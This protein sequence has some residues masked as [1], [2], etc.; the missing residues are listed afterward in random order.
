M[1]RFCNPIQLFANGASCSQVGGMGLTRGAY[2]KP[3]TSVSSRGFCVHCVHAGVRPVASRPRQA[4]V[5]LSCVPCLPVPGPPTSLHNPPFSWHNTA[6]LKQVGV[7]QGRLV[8]ATVAVRVTLA[9][10]TVQ[11]QQGLPAFAVICTAKVGACAEPRARMRDE[12]C[13]SAPTW[14]TSVSDNLL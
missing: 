4:G 2:R 12:G 6:H 14:A 10:G 11:T 9:T 5:P 7:A 8:D 13:A 3:G 1:V